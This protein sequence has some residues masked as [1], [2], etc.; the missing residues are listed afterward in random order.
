VTRLVFV[1]HGE[2]NV[3]VERRIG[4]SLT[5]T[6][7][8]PL[9]RKQAE[10]LAERLAHTGE[11]RADVLVTSTMPRARET[12][13]IISAG[14]GDLDLV[15]DEGVREHEPGPDVDGL[16]YDEFVD[17]YGMTDWT[18]DPYTTGFPGGETIAGFQHRAAAA[19]FRLA[20]A[21][22]GRTIVVVC[23]G[24]VIDVAFR[25]LLN[26]PL[27]GG[28]ELATINTSLTELQLTDR[29]RWRLVRYNDAAHL[30][31]LPAETPRG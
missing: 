23:H 24:G 7:L 28:F 4:G 22:A 14:L 6:G 5:C 2:S 8:S 29:N 1:R 18:I 26:L 15:V 25:A 30:A 31:G 19:I 12:A 3:S 17:R 27:T 21:H 13:E 11:L 10:A 20:K 9:G 16:R